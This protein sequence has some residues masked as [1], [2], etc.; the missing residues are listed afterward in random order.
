M[1]LITSRSFEIFDKKTGMLLEKKS[2][3]SADEY[4]LNILK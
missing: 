3:Q 2:Y 4:H 1:K